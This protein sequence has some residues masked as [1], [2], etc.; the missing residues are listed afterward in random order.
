M[1]SL[2]IPPLYT[3]ERYLEI[4][5]ASDVRNEF[6]DGYIVAMAGN[7]PEHVRISTNLARY[8][9]NAFDGRPCEVWSSDL[10]VLASETTY[11][12]P[13]ISVTCG[14]PIFL[15][16]KPKTLTNPLVVVEVLS[17][18][19]ERIDRREKFLSYQALESLQHYVLVSQ[20]RALIEVYTRQSNGHWD[21][22][23]LLSLEATL[24]LSAIDFSVPLSLIYRGV[25]FPVKLEVTEES[26][27]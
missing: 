18:S 4:D 19:T 7:T 3:V 27:S 10:R 26:A 16:T 1:S 22:V 15:P 14:E 21:Y 17:N 2:P 5:A 8:L 6:F 9:G 24:D 20:D 13:E 25:E 11:V 23:P 12:Y